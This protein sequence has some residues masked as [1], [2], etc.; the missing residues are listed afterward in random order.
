MF[1]R[2]A[3]VLGVLA[4]LSPVA[5]AQADVFNLGGTR[6]PTTGTWTGLA[7]LEFVTVGD[8]GNTGEQSRLPYGDSI[9]YGGV[10][11]T[12]QIGKYA[13]TVGQYCSFLNAVAKTDT[14]GLYKGGM[15]TDFSTIGIARSGNPGSYGYAVTGDYSQ[16][17]NCPIFDVSWGD[18]ARF[19]NWLQNGQP[20]GLQG[21]ATTER[22]AY[23]L[24]GATTNT[25]LTAVNRSSGA[26]YFLP[27][28]NEW[29]KAA[30]YKSGGINAGYWKYP[31]RSN[32]VPNNQFSSS[33]ANN[34]NLNAGSEDYP[35][36]TDPINGLTP[37]GAFLASPGPYGAFDLCGDVWLWTEGIVG[38]EARRIA[39]GCWYA[40]S[41]CL[42]SSAKGI[43]GAAGENGYVGFRVASVPEP[44]SLTML[45]AG[46]IGLLAHAWRRRKGRA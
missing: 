46:A 24:N 20:T 23:T 5:V 7:S 45:L 44:D 18:A 13:V 30:F 9:Y 25:A 8:P 6:N 1:R 36:Y 32:N 17:A 38:S 12:Y 42:D 26:T 31:T 22:G 14:Y 34:A 43:Y 19:C 41:Q 39:G 2:C 11:H 37:V 21:T 16:A 15:A 3:I 28:E 35:A 33:G 27:S 4:Y 40:G 10:G 29:Y